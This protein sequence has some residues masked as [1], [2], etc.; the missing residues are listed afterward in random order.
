MSYLQKIFQT[1]EAKEAVGEGFIE[2]IKTKDI[3]KAID[4]TLF[5]GQKNGSLVAAK[6]AFLLDLFSVKE[7]WHIH[8]IRHWRKLVLGIKLKFLFSGGLIL[9]GFFL[10]AAAAGIDY[11]HAENPLALPNNNNKSNLDE[12]NE[13]TSPGTTIFYLG[14][15]AVVV[16]IGF[17]VMHWHE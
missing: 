9:F 13:K 16:G 17:R 3:D 5:R 14:A 7:E 12:S 2:L 11:I 8:S 1:K 10:M 15:T 4:V 6:I